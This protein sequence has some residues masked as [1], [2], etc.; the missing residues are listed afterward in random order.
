M[1]TF[2]YIILLFTAIQV[3]GQTYDAA[4]VKQLYAK[5]PTVP[6][7]LCPACKYWDNNIYKS[8]ADTE[9]HYP[10]CEYYVYTKAHEQRQQFFTD[11]LTKA[12]TA[13]HKGKL[14]DARS[15]I[16]AEW[17]SVTGQ[18]NMAAIYK[19][20]N[21]QFKVVMAMGHVNAYI[22]CAYNFMGIIFS[23]TWDFNC[24]VE[25][26]GQNIGTEAALERYIRAKAL[27]VDTLLTWG[28]CFAG[29]RPQ[30]VTVGNITATVPSHFWKCIKYNGVI[31]CWWLPNL[32]T[33]TG[34]LLPK[35]TI[36][37]KDLILILGFDPQ[38]I[39]N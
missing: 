38:Q 34:D 21:A 28:G 4:Y 17:H 3:K 1:K 39:L 31:E 20:A 5:F 32:P 37:L 35:R 19:K 9:H 30:T 15:G 36:A 16:Y 29:D 12:F 13:Q 2:T 24:G 7:A 8:I 33:E 22:W 11:S 26:Q 18:P 27:T 6:S 25:F 14:T 10:V 23:D